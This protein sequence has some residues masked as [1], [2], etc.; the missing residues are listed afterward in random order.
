MCDV[1]ARRADATALVV[2]GQEDAL[3]QQVA[4][5]ERTVA[6]LEDELVLASA[7]A[8]E[9]AETRRALAAAS[10]EVEVGRRREEALLDLLGEKEESLA[11]LQMDVC[12]MRTIYKEQ[13]VE[14]VE[15]IAALEKM[16]ASL[17]E[18]K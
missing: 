16:L 15:K 4:L 5:L 11:E 2:G 13:V 14:L 10:N 6:A 3:R 9:V 8:D 18:M 1:A 12:D 17:K 7:S